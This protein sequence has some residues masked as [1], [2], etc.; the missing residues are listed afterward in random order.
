MRLYVVL[1]YLLPQNSEVLPIC[2]ARSR[3]L[4]YL[5]SRI[6]LCLALKAV[7][8]SFP[9]SVLHIEAAQVVTIASVGGRHY[10][11]SLLMCLT[12]TSSCFLVSSCF[13]SVAWLQEPLFLLYRLLRVLLSTLNL[14][15]ISDMQETSED[16]KNAIAS[17]IGAMVVEISRGE[18]LLLRR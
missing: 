16:L 6:S 4:R 14:L 7:D 13:L 18:V 15:A 3:V 9:G 10:S 1:V 11:Y 5:L 8:Q 12:S 2:L 17:S